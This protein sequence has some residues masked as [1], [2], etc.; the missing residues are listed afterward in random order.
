MYNILDGDEWVDE[1]DLE[2][3]NKCSA[4][5]EKWYNSGYK[6]GYKAGWDDA[7]TH[8]QDSLDGLTKK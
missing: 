8:I 4:P 6:D 3:K 1:L 7:I 5:F 2:K